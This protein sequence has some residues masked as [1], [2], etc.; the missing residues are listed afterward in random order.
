MQKRLAMILLV[1]A[2]SSPACKKP[3]TA[4]SKGAGDA[5]NSASATPVATAVATPFPTPVKPVVDQSAEVVIFGYH[6]FVK[7]VRRPDTELTPEAFEEQMKELKDKNISVIKMQDF[8]AWKRGEKS[9]PVHS[10]II[11]FDDGWKS[12]IE[13]AWPIMKKYGYPLTLFIYTEGIRGGH[14]G[15]GEAMSWEQ[16]A[17]M[18]DAGVDIQA[19][20]ETHQ[21][22]RRPYD[23]IARKKLNPEEYE[24]WLKNEVAGSKETLEHKLGIRV[25]C[26]AYPFGDH[27]AHVQEVAKKSGFDALFTVYGQKITYGTPLDSVGRYMIEANKPKVFET[28]IN[29]SGTSIGGSVP[30]A[31]IGAALLGAQPA[32]GANAASRTPTIRAN[33]AG[34]GKFDAS[35]VTMR[36]SGRGIVPAKFDPATK[37]ITFTPAKPLEGASCS[38]II[39]AKAGDRRISTN[40]T[41]VLN[42]AAVKAKDSPAPAKKP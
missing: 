42:P 19:H 8:L 31:E 16:L 12:Q 14:F 24:T 35:T 28:A 37:N 20:S 30:S 11:T 3:G 7:K 23:K 26:F 38:V 39:E 21:D 32:D 25:N 40:W 2:L 4:G 18:R 41:F 17:E 1:L 34:F 15:G 9:I 10:A 5:K 13:Y 27:N 22:L 6:R 33:L 29:F 36:L